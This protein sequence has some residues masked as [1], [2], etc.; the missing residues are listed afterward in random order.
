MLFVEGDGQDV[1]DFVKDLAV[2]KVG[3]KDEEDS[4]EGNVKGSDSY[5][6]KGQGKC[7][8]EGKGSSS[9]K[10]LCRDLGVD[11]CEQPFVKTEGHEEV[12]CG[13]DLVYQRRRVL[14]PDLV[15][16]QSLWNHPATTREANG[17]GLAAEG[18]KNGKKTVAKDL[19]K[20]MGEGHD[21]YNTQT[22]ASVLPW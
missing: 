3:N 2:D 17:P 12:V 19:V 8:E 16:K 7:E 22:R 9:E 13:D 1:E 18:G 11:D 14:M 6:I 20:G 21:D 15:P 10:H 5:N 4:A